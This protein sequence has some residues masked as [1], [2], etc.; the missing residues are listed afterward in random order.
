MPHVKTKFLGQTV[1]LIDEQREDSEFR[2]MLRF[3]E[4]VRKVIVKRF[5][6][7]EQNIL[8]MCSFF[9]AVFF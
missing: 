9:G 8:I 3:Y 7:S 2:F 1:A 6:P 5:L 4:R